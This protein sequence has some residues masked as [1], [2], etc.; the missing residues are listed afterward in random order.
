MGPKNFATIRKKLVNLF[1]FIYV[2]LLYTK[3]HIVII[4]ICFFIFN[5]SQ[6]KREKKGNGEEPNQAEMFIETRQCRKGKKNEETET[7]IV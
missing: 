2:S 3:Q 6:T 4:Y 7:A 5:I 1:I